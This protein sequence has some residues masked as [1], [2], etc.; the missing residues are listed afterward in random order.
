MHQ[1][2]AFTDYTPMGNSSVTG[3]GSKEALILGRRTVELNLTCNGTEYMLHLENILHVP[4]MRNN[5]ISLGQWDAAGG[6]YNGINGEITLITKN[7]T[8]V[9]QGTKIHNHLYRMKMVVRP[10]T[11]S[12]KLQSHQTFIGNNTLPT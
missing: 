10:P 12:N 1:R 7:G 6:C 8:P 11:Q 5:S 3:V 9:A 4:G 2:E